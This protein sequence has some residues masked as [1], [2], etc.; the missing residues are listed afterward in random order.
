VPDCLPFTA[1]VKWQFVNSESRRSNSHRSGVC[2]AVRKAALSPK[3]KF[4][5]CAA[6]VCSTKIGSGALFCMPHCSQ[7]RS[8]SPKAQQRFFGQMI[9]LRT[10][11]SF[12]YSCSNIGLVKTFTSCVPQTCTANLVVN[13]DQ[14]PLPP[15]SDVK[16]I[17]WRIIDASAVII[18]ITYQCI[19]IEKW[20]PR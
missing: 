10:N 16:D 5:F 9:K 7:K 18:L 11:C 12:R 4:D 2:A 19:E 6:Y 8:R 15:I 3:C 20:L 13:A 14:I 17:F 1:D